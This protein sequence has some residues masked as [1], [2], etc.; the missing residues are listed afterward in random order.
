[1]LQSRDPEN[2]Y[3]G[4]PEDIFS[5]RTAAPFTPRSENG[6]ARREP[7]RP[8]QQWGDLLPRSG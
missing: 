1:M 2:L 3:G 6:G 5:A 8:G 7:A 4:S